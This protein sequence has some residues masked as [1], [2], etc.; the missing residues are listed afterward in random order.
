MCPEEPRWRF[1]RGVRG[2][3]SGGG[4]SRG[5]RIAFSVEERGVVVKRRPV[6]CQRCILPF[7]L[8]Q[9]V[10]SIKRDPLAETGP[11]NVVVGGLI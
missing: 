6:P 7:L 4:S 8:L 2:K 1:C 11:Q 10:S 3:K 9:V 5:L